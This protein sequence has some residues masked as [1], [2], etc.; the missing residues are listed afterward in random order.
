M[1]S[2]RQL[3][4]S[5]LGHLVPPLVD[6]AALIA[7][8]TLAGDPPW[9]AKAAWD[10]ARIAARDGR[11]VA[12]VDLCLENPALH[13][14]AGLHATEG[15]VDAFEYGVSLNKAAHEVTGV[16]IIPAG[17]ETAHPDEVYA[18]ARWPK[19]QA[20]FRSEGALL[21]ALLPLTG[22]A[23]LSAAPDGA[24][25]LAP[26]G[27]GPEFALP[28]DVPLLG[29]VRDRWLPSSPR[30]SPPSITVPVT[31]RPRRGL[32]IALAALVVAALAVGGWALLA[33]ARESGF[34][35]P[36]PL[37]APASAPAPAHSSPL[38][39]PTHATIPKADT[40]GWTIQLAAYASLDKALA[41]ADRLAADAGVSALVTPV[42]QSGNGPVWYRVLAGSYATRAAAGTGRAALWH[43]GL[44]G[45]GVGDL[46]LAPYS[47]HA[48]AGA[49]LD[50]LR[51]RGLPAVRWSTG[52]ILLGA[53][54]GP[55]QAA[56]TQ[57]ALRR[58]GVR[59]NL[60]PRMGIP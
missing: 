46:L 45:E 18:H 39:A 24:L 58:A 8:V 2:V 25:V 32:R 41:H 43:R 9:A 38:P 36:P 22:L 59:A 37:P 47:Y 23:Q 33:R 51:R 29:V 19:L 52:V 16:F 12:L 42:P 49:S 26:E 5:R 35:V 3:P 50:S 7:L 15:I 10:I 20:G 6:D 28:R 27:V 21:L 40:L 56:Y 4:L 60:L 57:A 31:D 14:I 17:S 44:A 13:E 53:F 1:T 11:R 34:L 30:V 55:E 54:E 48:P